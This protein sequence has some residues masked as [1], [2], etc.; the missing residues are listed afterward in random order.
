MPNELE[1]GKIKYLYGSIPLILIIHLF[2]LVLFSLMLWNCVDGAALGVWAGISLILLLFRLYHYILYTN[3]DDEELKENPD[4]WLHRYYTYILLGGA[5]WGSTAILLFPQDDLLHQM[6]VVLFILGITATAI[7]II[8]ASWYLVV[9]YVL[10]SFSPLIIRLAWMPDP[11]YQTIA[12]IVSALGILMIF[13]AKHF[14]SVIDIAIRNKAEL[15]DTKSSLKLLH[16]R[17]G[18]LLANAPIGIFYYD[19]NLQITDLN[20]QMEQILGLNVKQDL[21]GFDLRTVSDKRILPALEAVF[22]RQ[23]GAY[24]GMYFSTVLEKNL[25]IRIHTA[26]L[27]NDA[28]EVTGAICFFKDMTGEHEAKET[29]RQNA[30]YDP[31]TKL[32]NRILF[33]DR[34]SLAIEQSKRHRYKCAVLFLDL[35]HFKHINDAYGHYIGDQLLYKVSQ[36]LLEAVRTEDTVARIGG[37]E[38]LILLN[39][40]PSDRA[41]AEATAMKISNHL[42][43]TVNDTYRIEEHDITISVSIGIY[44]FPDREDEDAASIIKHADV[45]MYQAKRSGRNHA[46]LY[47][48]DFENDQQEYLQMET[49]LRLALQRNE[50]VLYFQPKVSIKSDRIEQVEALIRWNHPD[51]GLLLPDEFIPFAE[52]SGQILK[53][54][55]WV[56][57]ESVRQIKAWQNGG[58]AAAIRNVA[59][60]V[61][62]NQFKQPDFVDYVKSVV[63]E[64]GIRPS[65]IEL[66][67]TEN[68]ML[69]NSEGAIDKIAEL[70]AFGIQIALD[71]FGTGYSSLSYL[72]TLPVS[73]IKIDRSFIADLK[74][75][76]NAYM[77]VKTIISVAKS[78]GLTV[79]AEGV[80]SEEEL[81]VLKALEC[82]YYQGF[83]CEKAVPADVLADIVDHH[84]C[85]EHRSD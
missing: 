65:M 64:H 51:K 74:H 37:D 84:R 44:L 85:Q 57:E 27:L 54:G 17:F 13:T 3:T 56:F 52:Q 69:D 40:L 5:L 33:S 32:P 35:D 59:V 82:D 21:V 10:L 42:I 73:I 53:I 70:E 41:K 55:K 43:E 28:D 63:T 79:I 7:G 11:L 78:L 24:E 30:F 81:K 36:R 58:S 2:S 83:L 29:I 34:L 47:H 72:N 68:V 46:E 48:V 14:G 23:E 12:Y 45:A 49:A 15:I 38:F 22:E 76:K 60:N 19:R 39:A 26:P 62:P 6:V 77:I 8:S 16:N 75:N 31:L 20:R 1:Y 50:F 61:S 67:L 71:D 66:E 4:L 80:E 18:A 9:A 25:Y